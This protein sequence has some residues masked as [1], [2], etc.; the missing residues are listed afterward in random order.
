MADPYIGEIRIFAGNYPPYGWFECNGQILNVQ[1]YEALFAVIGSVFG[2]S[3][4]TTFALPKMPGCAPVGV[5]RGAGLN[6]QYSLGHNQGQATVALT[7]SQM[8]SHSHPVNVT[9]AQTTSDP[10]PNP[11]GAKLDIPVTYNTSKAKYATF[12][13][14]A[15]SAGA[16]LASAALSSAG[17]AN[18]SAHTND[19]PSLAL[20]FCIAWTGVYPMRD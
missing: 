18:P 15:A 7:S 13:A 8:P 6:A 3:A 20:R 5:G 2:G 10:V 12:A 9:F 14:Y 11:A 19:Q 16:A 17:T 1:Q 4:P